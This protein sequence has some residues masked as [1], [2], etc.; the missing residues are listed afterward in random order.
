MNLNPPSGKRKT[1]HTLQSLKATNMQVAI[2]HINVWVYAKAERGLRVI[3]S[4]LRYRI[5]ELFHGH[6][7]TIAFPQQD[8]HVDGKTLL[9]SGAVSSA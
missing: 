2:F 8:V 6:D 5:D 1:P 4:D 9:Q 3:R 7:V